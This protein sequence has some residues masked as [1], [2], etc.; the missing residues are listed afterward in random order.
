[1]LGTLIIISIFVL[2]YFFVIRPL[3]KKY[4]HGTYHETGPDENDRKGW[5]DPMNPRSEPRITYKE[6]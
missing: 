1:M 6:W 5:Q 3:Q 2:F 4:M